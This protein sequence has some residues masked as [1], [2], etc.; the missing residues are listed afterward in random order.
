MYEP[1]RRN[2]VLFFSHSEI[3]QFKSTQLR[4]LEAIKTLYSNGNKSSSP[5]TYFTA[6]EFMKAVKIC[7]SKF[8]QLVAS[9]K[10]PGNVEQ[11]LF[12]LLLY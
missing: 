2:Q 3:E 12:P 10:D 8:D 7:R 4:I 9:S 6:V 1:C 5:P 11:K